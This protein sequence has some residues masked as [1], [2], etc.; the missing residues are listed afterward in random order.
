MIENSH[1]LLRAAWMLQPEW[2][3][4]TLFL[5]GKLHPW[6]FLIYLKARIVTSES[7]KLF[8]FFVMC[9]YLFAWRN[10]KAWL[11]I[12]EQDGYKWREWQEDFHL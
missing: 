1:K 7:K 4:N 12:M 5:E 6:R 9:A 10:H 8:D 11:G 3:K 2:W